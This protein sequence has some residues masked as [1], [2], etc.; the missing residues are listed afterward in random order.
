ME[1]G[2]IVIIVIGALTQYILLTTSASVQDNPAP[3]T[4]G[5]PMT[6]TYR[7]SFGNIVKFPLAEQDLAP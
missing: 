5:C 7:R 3:A 2:F 6:S 4:A 1:F